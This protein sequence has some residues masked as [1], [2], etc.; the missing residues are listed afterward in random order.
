MP[1]SGLYSEELA[2]NRIFTTF[3]FKQH[4]P[5]LF[6]RVCWHDFNGEHLTFQGFDFHFLWRCGHVSKKNT[7]GKY[8]CNHDL[9]EWSDRKQLE[10]SSSWSIS[11]RKVNRFKQLELTACNTSLNSAVN[12][13]PG[14]GNSS[15][16]FSSTSFTDI[17]FF[18]SKIFCAMWWTLSG[19]TMS[20]WASFWWTSKYP[21]IP[22][23]RNINMPIDNHDRKRW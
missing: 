6:H 3:A 22:I 16:S 20:K 23:R 2:F 1:R 4:R 21:L 12:Q 19:E 9:V 7:W 14:Q 18:V 13:I 10:K 5:Q 15:T 17:D 11:G 8:S